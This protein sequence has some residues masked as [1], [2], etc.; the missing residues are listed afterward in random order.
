MGRIF[1][2]YLD[3]VAT[4]IYACASCRAHVADADALVSKSFTGRHGRAYLMD[5]V[6]NVREGPQEERLLLTVSGTFRGSRARPKPVSMARSGWGG[7]ARGRLRGRPT[8]YPTS[9]SFLFHSPICSIFFFGVR[10][11][12]TCPMSLAVAAITCWAGCTCV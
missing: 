7:R 12:I 11:S 8:L 3:E 6:I 1:K 4:K 10:A 2:Q 5:K 9:T